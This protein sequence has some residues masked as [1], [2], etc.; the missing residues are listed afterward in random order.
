METFLTLQHCPPCTFHC[1]HTVLPMWSIM[2]ILELLELKQFYQ[3]PKQFTADH[4]WQLNGA[5]VLPPTMMPLLVRT[6][7]HI[8]TSRSSPFFSESFFFALPVIMRPTPLLSCSNQTVSL[9]HRHIKKLTQKLTTFLHLHATSDNNPKM[10]TLW[11][12]P[13]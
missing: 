3:G 4:P 5:G 7:C 2:T 1:K 6:V 9:Y 11:H 12:L 13:M 8:F 10:H